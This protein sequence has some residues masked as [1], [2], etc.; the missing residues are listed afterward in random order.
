M[1]LKITVLGAIKE[2]D[3]RLDSHPILVLKITVP[4][5]KKG[6]RKSPGS[7]PIL[8]LKITVRPLPMPL[9]SL[10]IFRPAREPLP[11]ER[12]WGIGKARPYNI[13]FVF[14]ALQFREPLPFLMVTWGSHA[15]LKHPANLVGK[16]VG[17]LRH[18]LF[19]IHISSP[20]FHSKIG[21]V[22]HSVN[23]NFLR[24]RYS[25]ACSLHCV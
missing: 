21:S 22:G 11:V 20:C 24:S 15:S 23:L 3:H 2:S 9:I 18:R 4:H 17:Y 16:L 13:P 25:C 8:V 10:E 5:T 7:H 14:K 12:A 1:V 6:C 19:E